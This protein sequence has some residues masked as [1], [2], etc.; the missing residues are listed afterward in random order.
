VNNANGTDTDQGAHLF[1]PATPPGEP[2]PL[3]VGLRA[4]TTV[5]RER[6]VSLT[7]N[8]TAMQFA[9]RV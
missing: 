1:C 6:R 2:A 3:P 8:R 9:R 7:D 4:L 5:P